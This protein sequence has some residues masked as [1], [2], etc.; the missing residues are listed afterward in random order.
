MKQA[1]I[2]TLPALLFACCAAFYIHWHCN[3]RILE[4]KDL[5]VNARGQLAESKFTEKKNLSE[6]DIEISAAALENADLSARLVKDNKELSDATQRL[7]K[8]EQE[9]YDTKTELGSAVYRLKGVRGDLTYAKLQ[10][11][12]ANDKLEGLRGETKCK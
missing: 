1:L 2:L 8:V 5:L 9:L 10:L 7:E 6:Y 11:G 4:L 3:L 12:L